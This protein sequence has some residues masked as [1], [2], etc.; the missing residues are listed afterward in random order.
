MYWSNISQTSALQISDLSNFKSHEK[1]LVKRSIFCSKAFASIGDCGLHHSRWQVVETNRLTER[2]GDFWRQLNLNNFWL[3]NYWLECWWVFF[4]NWSSEDE[5]LLCHV[6]LPSKLSAAPPRSLPLWRRSVLMTACVATA[7]SNS[8]LGEGDWHATVISA[9]LS[10]V[11]YSQPPYRPP[12]DWLRG[13]SIYKLLVT[14]T[15]L[16]ARTANRPKQKQQPSGGRNG[17]TWS[18]EWGSKVSRR[19]P[20]LQGKKM[21]FSNS[22]LLSCNFTSS[23]RR[24]LLIQQLHSHMKL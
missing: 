2:A 3:S 15:H 7:A 4:S 19:F 22:H 12:R 10:P 9:P 6:C 14:R 24:S 11:S 23:Q 20:E 21:L 5:L 8:S 13:S 18:C 16:Y 1:K 17:R